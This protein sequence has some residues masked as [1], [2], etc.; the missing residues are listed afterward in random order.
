[1]KLK[2]YGYKGCSTCKKAE[3]YL[4]K[5][6]LAYESVEI[7]EKAPTKSE[8]KAM[9]AHYG[10][11]LKKLFNTSGLVYRELKLGDKLDAMPEGQAL[12]L[13]AAN[14]K[15]VKRPF[16]MADGKAATVGFK[17]EEWEKLLGRR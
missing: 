6:N 14:G 3:A 7:T 1:M 2:I 12:D 5:N 4:N 11:Q 10:G 8:L 17:E 15:L 9:L 13:L 16:L